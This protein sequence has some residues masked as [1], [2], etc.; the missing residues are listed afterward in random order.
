M[1]LRVTLAEAQA[2]L[3]ELM[4]R[5]RSGE[6]V[7]ISGG[8]GDAFSLRPEPSPLTAEA[9]ESLQREAAGLRARMTLGGLD[10]KVLRDEGR[11]S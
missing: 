9:R 2:R 7:I 5:A 4:D 8:P 1:A 11:R 10:W 3:A 6:E